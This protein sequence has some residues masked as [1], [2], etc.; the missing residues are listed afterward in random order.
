[1]LIVVAYDIRDPKRL[2]L[3]ANVCKDYGVR[4]QYSVFECHLEGRQF[5]Q[6]WIDLKAVVHPGDD[7]LVAYPISGDAQRKVRT[8]GDMVCS[9]KV[10]AYVY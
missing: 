9:E 2:R 7:S 8:F 10:V 5:E 1:M 4:V 3:V 6:F